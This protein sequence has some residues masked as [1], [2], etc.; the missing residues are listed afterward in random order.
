MRNICQ[1]RSLLVKQTFFSTTGYG[2]YSGDTWFESQLVVSILTGVLHGFP[3]S[4]HFL[5]H[6]ETTVSLFQELHSSQM[7]LHAGHSHVSMCTIRWEEESHSN[8]PTNLKL[9]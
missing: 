4:C 3:V 1:Q 8:M 6:L 2:L 9:S 5:S 7:V